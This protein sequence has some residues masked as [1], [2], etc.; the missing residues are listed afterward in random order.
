MGKSLVEHLLDQHVEVVV[1]NRSP[2]DVAEVAKLGAVP[3]VSLPELAQKLSTP[4]IIWLMVLQGQPVDDVIQNLL[5]HLSPGDLLIDGGNSFFEDTLRRGKELPAKQIEFVD[6]GVSGGPSG[7]RSGACLMI[8]CSEANFKRIEP[9][10]R[11]LSAPGAYAH[12]GPV[13]SGHFAK[14]VHNGIEYGMMQS[15]AEGAAVLKKSQFNYKLADLFA[16]YNKKSV[17]ESR[18]VGWA[19]QAFSED[20]NLT[21]TSSAIGDLGEGEWT[22]KTAAK[23]GVPIPII[24]KSFEVRIESRSQP[25]SFRNKV[26]SA[27]RGQFGGHP[28]KK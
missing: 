19:Q 14:M 22:I 18:L 20:E 3:A 16:L 2:D 28:V 7:A 25:E 17:I 10:A 12:L 1:W 27:L 6:I 5:P 15:I 26:V 11:L 13:G 21:D 4:R 24:Q 8:G 23:I 9:L